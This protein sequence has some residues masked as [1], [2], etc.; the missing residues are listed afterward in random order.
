MAGEISELPNSPGPEPRWASWA[1]PA[2]G[3]F[4]DVREFTLWESLWLGEMSTYGKFKSRTTG[5]IGKYWKQTHNV[6]S[7][8]IF[9]GKF[10]QW[11]FMGSNYGTGEILD[12]DS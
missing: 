4:S 12:D 2:A 6:D 5:R 3:S 10:K 7:R 8:E 11:F 9:F 1:P